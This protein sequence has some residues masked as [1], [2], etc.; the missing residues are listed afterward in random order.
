MFYAQLRPDMVVSYKYSK[1]GRKWVNTTA[2]VLPPITLPLPTTL[3]TTSRGRGGRGNR[4]TRQ[5][6]AAAGTTET[7]TTTSALAPPPKKVVFPLRDALDMLSVTKVYG[8]RGQDLQFG[9]PFEGGFLS[10]MVIK[11]WPQSGFNQDEE[12]AYPDV[13]TIDGHTL[14]RSRYP[15]VSWSTVRKGG[16]KRRVLERVPKEEGLEEIVPREEDILTE[17]LDGIHGYRT[18]RS[19]IR[20]TDIMTWGEFTRVPLTY[21]RELA[22]QQA[23]VELLSFD[24]KDASAWSDVTP[25]IKA[26]VEWVRQAERH[27]Q[28][29][30]EDA[31]SYYNIT[32]KYLLNKL[33]HKCQENDLWDWGFEGLHDEDELSDLDDME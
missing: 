27:T 11:R 26:M 8:L 29:E 9:V 31:R 28:E 25:H 18:F 3:T 33:V 1:D 7:T 13:Y 16:R 4:R 21:T 23:I 20:L 32:G 2:V 22:L 15:E 6:T 12:D 24:G 14:K 30:R 5:T 10:E 19:V 17:V